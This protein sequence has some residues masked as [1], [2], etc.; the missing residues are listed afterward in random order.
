MNESGLQAS[1]GIGFDT[2]VEQ[3]RQIDDQAR[4]DR[5]RAV[6]IGLTLR[7]WSIGFYI[8]QHELKGED[9]SKYGD[10][11]PPC[12]LTEWPS[13]TNKCTLHCAALPTLPHIQR[14]LK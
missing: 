12:G 6:N 5:A 8:D 11:L 10:S 3:I 13:A 2:L 1:G 9:W 14:H 4:R 7:N